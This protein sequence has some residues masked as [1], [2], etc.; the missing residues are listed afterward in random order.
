MTNAHL[1]ID[2]DHSEAENI[3]QDA[4]FMEALR[5]QML[6]FAKLQV[7][8]SQLAEDAV[9]EAMLSAYQHIDRFARQAA[10]KTWVLSILKNKLIDLL[11]KEKRHTAASQLEEGPNLSGDALIEHLFEENGHWQ[12]DER[13]K[14]GIN[15]ITR[16]KMTISGVFS[17]RVWKSYLRNMAGFL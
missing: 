3:F 14:N 16:L 4:A 7:R 15:Q 5:V 6:K 11:R 1:S 13:P 8:D 12:K 17:M 9:Q 10:F 2:R